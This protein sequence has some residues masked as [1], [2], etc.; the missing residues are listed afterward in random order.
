[1]TSERCLIF[2]FDN[3]EGFA[4]FHNWWGDGLDERNKTDHA[5]EI[6]SM[7]G[8]KFERVGFLVFPGLLRAG[9]YIITGNVLCG[10]HYEKT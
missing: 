5:K 7:L 3:G 8:E 1:M 10:S 2:K 6:I 9:K 4:F